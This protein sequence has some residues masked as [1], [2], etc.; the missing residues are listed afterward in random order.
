VRNLSQTRDFDNI[1]VHIT[2]HM[3]VFI[4]MRQRQLSAAH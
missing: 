3:V 1:I 2:I 4:A